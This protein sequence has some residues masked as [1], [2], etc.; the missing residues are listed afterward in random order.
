MVLRV[1]V[2]PIN[3]PLSSRV[4]TNESAVNTAC[5]SSVQRKPGGQC[6]CH[7]GEMGHWLS[8]HR[9]PNQP[10]LPTH[11]FAPLQSPLLCRGLPWPCSSHRTSSVYLPSPPSHS[12]CRYAAGSRDPGRHYILCFTD[13]RSGSQW[14]EI[15]TIGALRRWWECPGRVL[16]RWGM[17]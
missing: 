1:V 17:G 8:S 15:L 7:T 9:A 5:Q 13:G 6:W 11:S 14:E 12:S 3:S 2:M 10:H 4:C 16:W